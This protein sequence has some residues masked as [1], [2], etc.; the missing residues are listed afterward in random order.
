AHAHAPA[1]IKAAV[2]SGARSIEHGVY[3]DDE[4]IELMLERGTWLVPTLTA[5]LDV[6]HRAEQGDVSL[7]TGAVQK[8]QEL[9]AIHADSF[10]RAVAAGVHV[11]MGT[12]SGVGVHGNNLAELSLMATAGMAPL[13]V[14]RAATS[15]AAQLL[16]LDHELGA[17]RAGLAA[18]LLVVRGDICDLV[19]LPE[20]ID[21]VMQ[22]GRIVFQQQR[23]PSNPALRA[24][25]DG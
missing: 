6:I 2:R 1:G 4:A 13:Q 18:D 9:A 3:L 22:S 14:L 7:P 24:G 20:R 11:A 19:T 8:A 17:V 16:R 10:A 21:S 25:S 12:D 23:E 15:G 5:P